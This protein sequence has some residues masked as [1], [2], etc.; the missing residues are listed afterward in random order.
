MCIVGYTWPV[1]AKFQLVSKKQLTVSS[2][3]QGYGFV[4]K[5]GRI[6][7]SF[8]TSFRFYFFTKSMQV[9]SY[10]NLALLFFKEQRGDFRII[11]DCILE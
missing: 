6:L 9:L 1:N 7:Y 11:S 3:E 8:Y 5:R 2:K 4:G 10:L